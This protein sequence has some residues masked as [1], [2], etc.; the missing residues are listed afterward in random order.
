MNEQNISTKQRKNNGSGWRERIF[1]PPRNRNQWVRR[2]ENCRRGL[3]K[4]ELWWGGSCNIS[5]V[6]NYKYTDYY[7]FYSLIKLSQDRLFMSWTKKNGLQSILLSV[8]SMDIPW[9]GA[10]LVSK[11]QGYYLSSSTTL[12]W[13]ETHAYFSPLPGPSSSKFLNDRSLTQMWSQA[14][15]I[16]ALITCS[17]NLHF[18]LPPSTQQ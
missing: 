1:V 18:C 14:L 4:G 11:E 15:P 5:W 13:T 17:C 8:K 9:C 7:Y 3:T 10:L 16:T 12:V 2:T 6:M